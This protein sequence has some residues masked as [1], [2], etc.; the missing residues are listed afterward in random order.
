MAKPLTES[1]VTTRSA[2]AALSLGLHWRSLDPDVHLG[3][4][5]GRRGGVWIVRWR[6]GACY[7]QVKLGTADDVIKGANLDY[8]AAAKLA[9]DTVERAHSEMILSASGP[10]PTVKDA[11]ED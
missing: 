8:A 4:R 2:R 5:K 6:D 11:V 10:T 3:Y 1:A 7:K 9:R